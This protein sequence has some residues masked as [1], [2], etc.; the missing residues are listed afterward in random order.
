M[1]TKSAACS[2][3]GY[4][5]VKHG[6]NTARPPRWVGTGGEKGK[7]DATWLGCPLGP[8]C[9]HSKEAKAQQREAGVQKGRCTGQEE[10]LGGNRCREGVGFVLSKTKEHT[11]TALLM[12]LWS[13]CRH[14]ESLGLLF[15]AGEWG[16]PT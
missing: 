16:L 14:W 3:S 13:V 12:A 4:S 7:G 2:D 5:S 15:S 6:Q 1:K 10:V 9:G 8:S 11:A